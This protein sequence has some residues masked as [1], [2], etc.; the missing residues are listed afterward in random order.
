MDAP[1]AQCAPRLI[2]E[3]NTG[4]CRIQT[5]FC[6]CASMAQPTEQC[7]HTVRLTSILPPSPSL[8]ASARP[9]TL[10]GSCEATAPAPTVKPE[11]LRNARRS[12]VLPITADRPRDRRDCGAAVADD[13]FVS[14]MGRLLRLSPSG[15]NC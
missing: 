6:T 5:P 9:M 12:S 15:S 14:S 2:G 1:F 3:S 4:S 11:R 7:V 8:A 10:K 13:F